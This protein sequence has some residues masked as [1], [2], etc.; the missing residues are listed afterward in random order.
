S[1]DDLATLEALA[2]ELYEKVWLLGGTISGEHGDGLSRTSFLGGQYGPLVNVF[3]ELKQIF[4][5]HGLLNPGKIV[6]LEPRRIAQDLRPLTRHQAVESHPGTDIVAA[7]NGKAVAP[8]SLQLTWQA[9]EMME[10]ARLCNGCGACR[11]QSPDVRMC[12]I[13]R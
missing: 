7:T 5:P 9:D 2:A 1:S 4:D 6:P 12:P 10:A 11:S 8:I 3:R 13:F